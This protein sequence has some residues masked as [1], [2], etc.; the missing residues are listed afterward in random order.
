MPFANLFAGS[1]V[2]TLAPSH[3]LSGYIGRS[4]KTKIVA[5]VNKSDESRPAAVSERPRSH[6][7]RVVM[8]GT[9]RPASLSP[10]PDIP[11]MI[12]PM[13]AIAAIW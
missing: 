6:P 2:K 11:H 12:P 3:G 4:G 7:Q 10:V 5:L 8:L 1:A 9:P 13:S